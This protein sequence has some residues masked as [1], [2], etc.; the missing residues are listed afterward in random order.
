MA[1]D[2]FLE[3]RN[4]SRYPKRKGRA[5]DRRQFLARATQTVP[6]IVLGSA[7]L[8]ASRVAADAPAPQPTYVL[9]GHLPK[10]LAIGMFI[11]NWITMGGPRRPYAD[12]PQ[13]MAGLVERGFNAVR[14]EVGLNWCFRI[15]GRPRGEIGFGNPAQCSHDVL[16]RVVHLMELAKQHGIYVILS[17]WE[18]QDS[19]NFVADPKIREEVMAV[20]MAERLMG[21]ARQLDRLLQTLKERDLHKNVAFAEVANEINYSEFPQNAQGTKLHTEAIAFLRARHPDILISA[22]YSGDTSRRPGMIPENT[23]VYDIHS[24]T[25]APYYPLYNATIGSS[26]GG[27]R[28]LSKPRENPQLRRLLKE[29]FKPLEPSQAKGSKEFWRRVD[30]LYSNVDRPAFE[31]WLLE[32][33]QHNNDQWRAKVTKHFADDAKEAA[34]RRIP[35]V[36]DEGGYFL[37]TPWSQFELTYPGMSLFDLRIDLAIKHGYWGVMPTTYC[38]PEWGVWKNVE[39]LKTINGRFLAGKMSATPIEKLRQSCRGRVAGS[40]L[41]TKRR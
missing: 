15:D 35:A 25:G 39:W 23:Q 3:N 24:Y 33:Y 28:D 27:F 16:K 4:H 10:K 41:R 40:R 36:N 22:D 30:W 18:Y 8:H 5:M 26:G 11:W 17:D 7:L 2:G 1:T 32:E 14:V 9:P 21:L 37:P 20:P 29:N 19:N 31:A 13:V 34:L 12:L 38:G 6:S